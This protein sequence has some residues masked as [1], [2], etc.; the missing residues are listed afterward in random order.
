MNKKSKVGIF[1]PFPSQEEI[2]KHAEILTNETKDK[3]ENLI[4]LF[5]KEKWCNDNFLKNL[6]KIHAVKENKDY[7]YAAYKSNKYDFKILVFN[8]DS[9]KIQVSGEIQGHWKSNIGL[10]ELENMSKIFFRLPK[11]YKKKLDKGPKL[12]GTPYYGQPR[13]SGQIDNYLLS[14]V[15]VYETNSIY[16]SVSK[17]ETKDK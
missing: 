10:N 5:L 1:F 6:W 16:W 2:K 17:I 12:E 7:F 15:Y 8:I 4:S 13:L 14:V 11:S 3:I 9:E